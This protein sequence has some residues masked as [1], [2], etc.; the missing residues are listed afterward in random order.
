VD[1]PNSVVE[2]ASGWMLVTRVTTRGRYWDL[3]T[4]TGGF[5]G[6]REY[7][8]EWGGAV[9]FDSARNLLWMVATHDD[10]PVLV[11]LQVSLGAVTP[12]RRTR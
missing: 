9:G 1:R 5:A 6:S 7:P 11:R 2:V 10:A 4:P 8:E 12:S 3:F